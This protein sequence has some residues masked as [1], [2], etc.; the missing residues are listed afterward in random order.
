M[1]ALTQ[2]KLIMEIGKETFSLLILIINMSPLREPHS[3][4]VVSDKNNHNSNDIKNNKSGAV[5]LRKTKSSTIFRSTSSSQQEKQKAT[6]STDFSQAVDDADNDSS[7]ND[8]ELYEKIFSRC[9][10]LTQK[11]TLHVGNEKHIIHQKSQQTN[12][13]L[14]YS[15]PADLSSSSLESS[16]KDEYNIDNIPSNSATNESG[17]S[18]SSQLKSN[19]QQKTQQ[20]YDEFNAQLLA[21]ECLFNMN[22]NKQHHES[23]PVDWYKNEMRITGVFDKILRTLKFNFESIKNC[24]SSHHQN[25]NNNSHTMATCK[26]TFLFN[27]YLRYFNFLETIMQSST[28]AL[29]SFTLNQNTKDSKKLK[30]IGAPNG[31]DYPELLTNKLPVSTLNQNYL[32]DFENKYLLGLF[33][34]YE[35][36]RK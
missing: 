2:D 5:G 3:N 21:M 15:N 27:K 6:A 16:F 34:E 10:S 23:P 11:L 8:F 12:H 31:T 9:K 29:A 35:T 18:H 7:F 14:F 19:Q 13:Q 17:S 28:S 33:K 22:I 20:N 30:A 1:F 32:V 26:C 25:N 4:D 24:N 36:K